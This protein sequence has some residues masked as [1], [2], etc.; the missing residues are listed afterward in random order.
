MNKILFKKHRVRQTLSFRL[1]V[2]VHILRTRRTRKNKLLGCT[3]TPPL[4]KCI[5]VFAF[6]YVCLKDIVM[7]IVE[8]LINGSYVFEV[9]VP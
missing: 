1:Y 2:G 3:C 6:I 9:Y 7:Q 5:E 8:L 4:L